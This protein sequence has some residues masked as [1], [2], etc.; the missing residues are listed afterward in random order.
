MKTSPTLNVSKVLIRHDRTPNVTGSDNRIRDDTQNQQK[1]QTVH[2]HYKNFPPFSFSSTAALH[3]LTNS[4]LARLET[5]MV[6]YASCGQH[7]VVWE[8][9]GTP[10]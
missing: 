4:D 10:S 1:Q 3:I 9:W 5:N 2:G 6:E 8:S 7:T